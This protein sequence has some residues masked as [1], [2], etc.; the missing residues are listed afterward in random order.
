[1]DAATFTVSYQLKI[2]ATAVFLVLMLKWR[3][4]P[5]QWFSLFILV[6]GVAM[7]ELVN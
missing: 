1:L 4:S 5:M 3:L 6:A 7:V 2:L